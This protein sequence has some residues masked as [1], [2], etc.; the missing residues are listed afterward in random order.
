MYS[1]WFLL[2]TLQAVTMYAVWQ[3][4]QS[5]S[6]NLIAADLKPDARRVS[7]PVPAAFGLP[8]PLSERQNGL[9][10]LSADRTAAVY[11][12]SNLSIAKIETSPCSESSAPV[13]VLE[14]EFSLTEGA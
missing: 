7:F 5:G 3:I 9:E 4:R 6:R 14:D 12:A 11:G 8:V 13:Y 2:A 1:L 10:W